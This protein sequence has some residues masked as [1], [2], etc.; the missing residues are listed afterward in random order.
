M[1]A[2]IKFVSDA[3]GD[4]VDIA[5]RF[6]VRHGEALQGLGALRGFAVFT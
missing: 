6:C 5:D 2:D 1:A 4:A 3:V